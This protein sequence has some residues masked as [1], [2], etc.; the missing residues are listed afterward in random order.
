MQW[1]KRQWIILGAGVGAAVL[2]WRYRSFTAPALLAAGAVVDVFAR[3]SRLTHTSLD[4]DGVIQDDP[5]ALVNAAAAVVGRDVS[6]DAYALARMG[7]SEGVDG[8]AFRMFVALN[9]LDELQQHYGT[10]VYSGVA[11]LMLHSKNALSDGR[12]SE[13]G[14]GKRYATPRDPYEG[15]LLLA[16]QVI[17]RHAAGEDPTGGAVKFV[18]KDSFGVQPGTGS[19]EAKVADWADDGLYPANLD[20]ATDN[21]VVFRRGA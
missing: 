21:F 7:R 9:D 3:G 2:V 20:G 13:Q 5:G 19:Y 10:H 18:D 17:A 12:F 6:A 16:E 4:D 11:A 14:L 8:M 15:D 1:G